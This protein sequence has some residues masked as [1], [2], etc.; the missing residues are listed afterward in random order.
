MAHFHVGPLLFLLG[1]TMGTARFFKEDF[2]RTGRME[3]VCLFM[4]LAND[5]T[6]ERYCSLL[7]CLGVCVLLCVCVLMCVCV[8]LCVCLDVCV[9]LVC[10]GMSPDRC[11]V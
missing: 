10:S 7:V 8:L 4:N 3:N 6:I 2:E 5:P 1:V 11:A 9:C